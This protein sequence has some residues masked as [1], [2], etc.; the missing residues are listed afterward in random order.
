MPRIRFAPTAVAAVTLAVALTGAARAA[1][2]RVEK[3]LDLAPGGELVVDVQ[4]GGV[5]VTGGPGSGAQVEITA[6]RDVTDKFTFELTSEPGR[7]RIVSKRKGTSG[8]FNWSW[9]SANVHFEI[10]VPRETKLDVRSS[11][12]GIRIAGLQ[13]DARLRSSG[14]G[15]HAEDV[16]GNVDADT[17]GGGVDARRIDGDV[18]LETSGGGIR[19]ADISGNVYAHTSGGG[20]QIDRVAG[21][22]DA[23]SSGGGV[24][25][26]DI[27]GRILAESSGGPVE[28]VLSSPSPAGGKLS[29]SGGGVRVQLSPQ[30]HLNIDASSSGGGV[31]CDLPLMV[32]GKVSRHELHGQLNGG[33]PTLELDSSGGGVHIEPNAD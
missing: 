18:K 27:R 6:D 12:G 33:G 25:V 22:L 9:S 32:K 23:G 1:D 30:A 29:S 2:W 24:H 28:A 7:A 21:D 11:G 14:G 19:A 31:S 13:G 8:W 16:V 20:V 4:S 3:Q 17:S 5:T 10:R 15:L 26:N